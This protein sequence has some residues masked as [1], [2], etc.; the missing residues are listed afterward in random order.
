MLYGHAPLGGSDGESAV[1]GSD[2]QVAAHDQLAGSAP[3]RPFNHGDNRCGEQLDE[4][5]HAAQG[6]VV[7]ERVASVGGQLA[8]VMARGKDV[9]TGRGAKDD[10]AGLFLLHAGEGGAKL[11]NQIFAEC[12]VLPRAVKR[13]DADLICDA[14]FHQG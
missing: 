10:D 8:N 12:V 4:A 1:I 2:D 9:G 6:I 14:G 5:D 7:S 13:Q 11:V 3:H